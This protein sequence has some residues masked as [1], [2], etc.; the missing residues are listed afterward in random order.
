[1][2][3]DTGLSRLLQVL[4]S[5]QGPRAVL[6]ALEQDGHRLEPRYSAKGDMT[7][8]LF[9]RHGLKD[10]DVQALVAGLEEANNRLPLWAFVHAVKV[11]DSEM[12]LAKL[13]D[14]LDKRQRSNR[15][16]ASRG[17]GKLALLKQ[18]LSL[19]PRQFVKAAVAVGNVLTPTFNMDGSQSATILAID[20]DDRNAWRAVWYWHPGDQMVRAIHRLKRAD[21]LQASAGSKTKQF[22]RIRRDDIPRPE[23][24]GALRMAL[25]VSAWSGGTD[26]AHLSRSDLAT[27]AA[28]DRAAVSRAIGELVGIGMVT[29]ARGSIT[30][31]AGAGQ[32]YAVVPLPVILG[33]DLGL[34]D[35]RTLLAL[36]SSVGKGKRGCVRVGL[37]TI[38]T[39]AGVSRQTVKAAVPRLVRWGLV[40]VTSGQEF[41]GVNEYDVTSISPDWTAPK[42]ILEASQEAKEK[43][44]QRAKFS[45]AA[46]GQKKNGDSDLPGVV[47]PAYRVGDSNCPQGL[48]IRINHKERSTKVPPAASCERSSLVGWRRNPFWL[49]PKQTSLLPANGRMAPVWG[50]A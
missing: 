38:A 23:T 22:A 49:A 50:C 28:M 6:D 36:L 24:L 41:G 32:Y 48:T 19:S 20:G 8:H 9:Y 45:R 31:V 12:E 29:T 10:G 14:S 25:L 37:S 35:W 43:R 18:L 3:V 11:G 7:R 13:R 40:S 4:P 42:A 34:G 1:M 33:A 30:W 2:V 5:L 26:S 17:E 15:E 27:L 16:I 47:T 39:R 44:K 46:V 21:S